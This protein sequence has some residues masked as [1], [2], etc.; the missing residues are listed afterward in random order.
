MLGP[1]FEVKRQDVSDA[2]IKQVL[3]SITKTS[4]KPNESKRCNSREENKRRLRAA[5]EE[6]K[7][8]RIGQGSSLQ[9]KQMENVQKMFQMVQD[10]SDGDQAVDASEMINNI[11]ASSGS[12]NRKLVENASHLL[13]NPEQIQKILEK[14]GISG[15]EIASVAKKLTSGTKM[16]DL[17]AIFP[18]PQDDEEE[19]VLDSSDLNNILSDTSI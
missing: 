5:V 6:R 8:N 1:E 11:I 16:K 13:K 3:K 14:N 19:I 10:Q 12:S 17:S 7:L 4:D 9:S 15:S 18:T 2:Q